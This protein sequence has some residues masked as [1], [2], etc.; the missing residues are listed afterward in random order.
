MLDGTLDLLNI[1]TDFLGIIP[2]SDFLGSLFILLSFEELLVRV[3]I[4][5][6]NSSLGQHLLLLLNNR[7]LFD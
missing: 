7:C 5:I 4:L 1:F 3:K 2:S 6:L